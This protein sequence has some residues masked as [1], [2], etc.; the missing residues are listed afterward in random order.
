MGE[1]CRHV[2]PRTRI[3]SDL[4]PTQTPPRAPADLLEDGR[5][6]RGV[7][8]ELLPLGEAEQDDLHVL[9]L[10]ERDAQRPVGRHPDVMRQVRDVREPAGAAD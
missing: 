5:H 7:L 10:V 2:C 3:G 6:R 8:G 9:V 4:L 1:V